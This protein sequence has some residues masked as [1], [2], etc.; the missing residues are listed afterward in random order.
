EW[1]RMRRAC[2][3]SVDH[4]NRTIRTLHSNFRNEWA[5]L[6]T[7]LPAPPCRPPASS[8]TLRAHG[9]SEANRDRSRR[10]SPPSPTLARKTRGPKHRHHEPRRLLPELPSQ[11]LPRRRERTRRRAERR[12]GPRN[13]LR[14]AVLGVEGEASKTRVSC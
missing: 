5:F 7:A 2:T 4:S 12:T 1:V 11:V 8:A 13:H 3:R 10:F 6:E 14:D 9:R